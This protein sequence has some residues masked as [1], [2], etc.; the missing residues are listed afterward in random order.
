MKIYIK[1]GI[2]IH[3]RQFNDYIKSDYNTYLLTEEATIF[4]DS[5]KISEK[6]DFIAEYNKDSNSTFSLI[7]VDDNIIQVATTSDKINE[8]KKLFGYEELYLS[9]E[10]YKVG[11]KYISRISKE[12][13]LNNFISNLKTNGTVKVVKEDGTELDESEL[14]GTGM[15]LIITKEE[16]KIE[17]KIAVMADLDGNGKVTAT[18]LSTV[19]KIVLGIL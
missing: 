13:T 14:V 1:Y 4:R 2:I 6:D 3:I 8:I 19:N 7:E 15:T 17:L 12:T 11:D 16:E 10:M 9:T 5:Y 18:D